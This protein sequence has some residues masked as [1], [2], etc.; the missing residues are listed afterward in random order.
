MQ[1]SG[2]CKNKKIHN[3]LIFKIFWQIDVESFSFTIWD[4]KFISYMMHFDPVS[5]LVLPCGMK[6]YLHCAGLLLLSSVFIPPC[7]MKKQVCSHPQGCVVFCFS[8]TMWDEKEYVTVEDAE[9]FYS[10]NSTMWDEKEVQA[11]LSCYPL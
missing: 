8:F 9:K 11:L 3:L 6:S 10:F 2:M 7:G 5:V 1:K 4:E